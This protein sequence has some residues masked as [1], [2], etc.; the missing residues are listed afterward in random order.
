ME[1]E[2]TRMKGEDSHSYSE[3][4]VRRD[5]AVED[6][7]LKPQV[8]EEAPPRAEQTQQAWVLQR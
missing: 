7:E 2:R 1:I 3:E 6:G 5:E 8:G 4:L